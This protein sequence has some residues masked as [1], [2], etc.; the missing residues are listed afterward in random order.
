MLLYMS[1]GILIRC[2]G[3]GWT[4]QMAE[5]FPHD[6]AL[7]AANDRD[8]RAIGFSRSLRGMTLKACNQPLPFWA[9]LLTSQYTAAGDIRETQRR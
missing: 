7:E 3:F 4:A 5:D 1:T 6:E 2:S 8:C 9:D